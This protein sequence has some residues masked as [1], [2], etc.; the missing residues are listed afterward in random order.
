MPKPRIL[1]PQSVW[2]MPVLQNAFE[3]AGV[4]NSGRHAVRLLG[5]LIRHPTATWHDVP[6]LPKA[7]IACLES[8]FVK[9]TSSLQTIQRSTDGETM[10]LLLKLQ[11]GL[12]IEVVVMK[13]DTKADDGDGNTSGN[14]RSTL[15]V[16]SQVGCQM[17]CTFCATGT[18]GLTGNLSA[19][20]IAEQLAYAS[21]LTRIRNIVFMGMGEPLNNYNA[22]KAALDCMTDSRLFALSPRH[23][24]VST[25]GVTDKIRALASD[26]PTVR[27][28]LS[29]HAPTQPLRERIVPSAKAYKLPALLGAVRDYVDATGNR[30]F[31]E[32]VMLRGVNDEAEHAQELAAVLA[33][34]P[35]TVNLIPWNPVLSPDISFAAPGI[36]RVQAFRD[37][38]RSEHDIPCTIRQEKGQDIAGACGQLVIDH[39]NGAAKGLEDIEEIAARL[40]TVR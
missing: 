28:A 21:Q 19:G 40:M 32:Y 35:V 25:V 37:V 31:V 8:H 26:A 23:V 6:D 36:E 5:Y 14:V 11:D 39:K 18:M 7:A 29:L 13:Y 1:R 4:A 15:C 10:K 22:V 3:E 16:S 27:L 30:V 17:G 24:T 12:A 2:D 38:L 33:D 34:L 20:E 9:F